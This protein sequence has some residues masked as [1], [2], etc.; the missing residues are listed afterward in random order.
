MINESRNEKIPESIRIAFEALSEFTVPSPDE[1]IFR[2]RFNTE[3]NIESRSENP[4][5][6]NQKKLTGGMLSSCIDPTRIYLNQFNKLSDEFD[7]S[8]SPYLPKIEA[9]SENQKQVKA[10]EI[11]VEQAQTNIENIHS[12]NQ[13]YSQAK[14]KYEQLRQSYTQMYNAEG[15]I[16]A[17]NF[18]PILY[19]LILVLIGAVEWLINYSSFLEFYSVPA[20]AAGFTFAVSLAVACASHWHGSR[21]KGSSYF[22]GDHVEISEKNKEILA[23]SFATAALLIAICYVGWVRY[24]WAI[25][26]VSQL[27]TSNTS[28]DQ[29][30]T[31]P[32]I[33]VGQKVVVSLVANLLVW[34]IGAA[35]AYAVHDK[36]PKFTDKLREYNKANKEFLALHKPIEN[37]IYQKRSNLA[38]NI[39]ELKNIATAISE[40]AAP[41]AEIKT[42]KDQKVAKVNSQINSLVNVLIR[43]YQASLSSIASIENP[44]LQFNENGT[45]INLE[46]YRQLQIKFSFI[47]DNMEEEL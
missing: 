36:N 25:D 43:N 17:K 20:M 18:P 10:L 4:L 23:I 42:I 39:H 6:L 2:E 38:K 14:T 24:S 34:F 26:L 45:L 13:R 12:S 15:Q 16:E 37:E 44:A 46:N 40:E 28:I 29:D 47:E 35:F 22:F 30:T 27:G 3:I 11:E 41:L 19:G 31:L 21:L 1:A 7:I 5:L 9:L 33:D 32:T 8:I